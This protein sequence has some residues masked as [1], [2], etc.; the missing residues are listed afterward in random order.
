MKSQRIFYLILVRFSGL[1]RLT[2]RNQAMSQLCAFHS[3]LQYHST[4]TEIS[5]FVGFTRTGISGPAGNWLA[6][7]SAEL[8]N[9]NA[10]VWTPE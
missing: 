6:Y 5:G 3:L 10:L 1:R 9:M 4:T 8:R 7:S 2:C